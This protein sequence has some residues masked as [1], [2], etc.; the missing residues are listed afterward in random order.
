MAPEFE[1]SVKIDNTQTL[2]LKINR[3]HKIG[4]LKFMI[5]KS[6]NIP[7]LQQTLIFQGKQLQDL[8]TVKDYS[9][10]PMATLHLTLLKGNGCFSANTEILLTKG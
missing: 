1:V 3:K 4:A 10:E 5:Y 2:T 6:K 9:I 7:V 8:R